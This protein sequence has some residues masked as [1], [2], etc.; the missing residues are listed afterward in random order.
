MVAQERVPFTIERG[1]ATIRFSVPDSTVEM[2]RV[3]GLDGGPIRIDNLPS[4]VFYEYT[5]YESVVHRHRSA[6]GE[7]SAQ[8]T[9]GFTSKMIVQSATA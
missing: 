3:N 4:L 6:S 7:F 1:A 2:K 8:E 9:N 5:Q